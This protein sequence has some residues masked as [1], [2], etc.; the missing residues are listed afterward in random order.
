MHDEAVFQEKIEELHQ[1]I[2]KN[3]D[4][5]L[6]GRDEAAI[7]FSGGIDSALLAHIMSQNFFKPRLY[8]MGFENSND[9]LWSR[10]AAGLLGLSLEQRLINADDVKKAMGQIVNDVGMKNPKWMSVFIPFFLGFQDVEEEV[11]LVGQGADELFGGYRKYREAGRERASEMM[12]SDIEDIVE[13]EAVYYHK[14]AGHFNKKLLLP[15]LEPDILEFGRGL[16][17]EY[18]ISGDES[19]V[20]IRE[21]GRW[22]GLPDDI[23]SRPKKAMQYGTGTSKELRKILKKSGMSL[24]EYVSGI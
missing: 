10:E 11:V 15:Y 6:K 16:P 2:L 4:R 1:L 7:L 9:I 20:I 13:E 5:E 8:S 12:V 22:T 19:K 14:V 17:F 24:K 18:K 21:M 3:L 23:A